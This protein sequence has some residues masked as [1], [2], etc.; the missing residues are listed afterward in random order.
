[1]ERESASNKGLGWRQDEKKKTQ[2]EEERVSESV[3]RERAGAC[4]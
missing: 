4:E 1:M 3:E 2:R